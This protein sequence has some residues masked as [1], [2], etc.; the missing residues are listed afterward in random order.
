M[1]GNTVPIHG[2]ICRIEK[3]DVN[4]EFSVDWSINVTVDLA[5]TSRQGQAWKESLAGQSG[6]TGSMTFHLV[7]DN[8]EQKALLDNIIAAAP[9]TKLTDLEFV[10][11]DSGDH[12]AG[13]I[14]L[15]TFAVTA[16]VGDTVNCT[17][18]FTGD[19]ALTLTVA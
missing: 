2:R 11:E 10:L 8:T 9:G 18:D 3:N 19:G 4:V 16:S 12:L 7:T 15:T 5:D 17:F 1:A 6:W 14:F 13:D